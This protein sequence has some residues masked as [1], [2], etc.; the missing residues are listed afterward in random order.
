M[1]LAFLIQP[2]EFG[3]RLIEAAVGDDEQPFEFVDRLLS[4]EVFRLVV[5]TQIDDAILAP[6]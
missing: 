6:A 5:F 4:D 3:D 2:N 1:G